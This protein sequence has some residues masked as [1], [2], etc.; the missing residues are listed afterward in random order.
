MLHIRVYTHLL[1][2]GSVL[3]QLVQDR[4]LFQTPSPCWCTFV[5]ELQSVNTLILISCRGRY[6][7]TTSTVS[8]CCRSNRKLADQYGMTSVLKWLKC[9]PGD[10]L[11]LWKHSSS[12]SAGI[13]TYLLSTEVKSICSSTSL[14]PVILPVLSLNGVS[15]APPWLPKWIQMSGFTAPVEAGGLWRCGLGSRLPLQTSCPLR[16]QRFPE[17]HRNK[18]DKKRNK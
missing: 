2:R 9:D 14:P 12:V 8:P 16:V 17:V 1:S 6:F 11:L 10:F 15:K 4:A 18:D 13:Y 5:K 3:Q 7:V